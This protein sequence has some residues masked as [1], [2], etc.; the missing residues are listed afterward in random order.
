MQ[1]KYHCINNTVKIYSN[2]VIVDSVNI[3]EH[4]IIAAG[5]VVARN[6]DPYTVVGGVAAKEIQKIDK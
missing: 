5:A 1:E 4:S 2:L 3:G 6:V